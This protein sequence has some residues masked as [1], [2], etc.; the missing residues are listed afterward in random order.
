MIAP[1]F[2]KIFLSTHAVLQTNT[3]D[4]NVWVA[5]VD[6]NY[7]SKTGC[8]ISVLI[9]RMIELIIAGNIEKLY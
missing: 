5:K 3:V 2:T 9:L 1:A 6:I 4:L 7:T 8:A